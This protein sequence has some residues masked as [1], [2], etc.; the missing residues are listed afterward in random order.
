MEGLLFSIAIGYLLGSLSPGYFLGRFVK[1]KDIRTLGNKN[2]GATNTYREVGPAYGVIAGLFDI[3]KSAAVYW[4]ALTRFGL[5]PDRA[6]LAGLGAVFGHIFPFY[7]GFRG[8]RGTATLV[9]LSAIALIYTRSPYVLALVLGTF[10]YA[11][12][13]SSHVQWRVSARKLLKL[14]ALVIPLGFLYEP[15]LVRMFVFYGLSV[16]AVFEVVR[17]FSVRMNRWYLRR[18]SFA[19]KKETVR[20][21]GYTLFFISAY[22]LLNYFPAN[23]A[24]LALT[25]FVVADTVGPLGGQLL[26][27]RELMRGKTVGGAVMIFASCLLAGIFLSTIAAITLPLNVIL[28]GAVSVAVLDLFSFAIDDNLLIPIG[29]ALVMRYWL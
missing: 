24:V 15:Q 19:K 11:I 16:F 27:R 1:G 20:L 18:K 12:R 28:W 4:L 5:G 26:L 21:T 23:I 7:L 25:F 17:A 10:I 6:I 14:G 22:V 8:G 29:S 3:F 2:T 13:I 9:G